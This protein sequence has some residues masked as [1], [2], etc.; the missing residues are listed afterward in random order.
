MYK[1]IN[2]ILFIF[3]L[4]FIFNTVKAE[5]SNIVDISKWSFK[6]LTNRSDENKNVVISK[7]FNV[8]D[9]SKYGFCIEPTQDFLPV[10]SLYYEETFDNKNIYNIV[11]AYN[12]IGLNNDDYYIAAQLLIWEELYQT[13]YTFNGN[14]YSKYKNEIIEYIKSN[15]DAIL[16]NSEQIYE[17][18][19]NELVTI[20]KDFSNY[21]IETDGIEIVEKDNIKLIYKII[22]KYPIN[23]TIKFIPIDDNK[24]ILYKSETSQDIYIHEGDFIE[25]EP[26]TI[27]V[28]TLLEPEYIDLKYSKKDTEGNVISNAE[29]TLFEINEN[30]E[31]EITFIQINTEIDLIKALLDN[32]TLYDNLHIEISERYSKYIKNNIINTNELGYFP[33]KIYDNNVLIKE[34]IVFVTN[35]VKQSNGM[36]SRIKTKAIFKGFSEDLSINNINNIE[37]DKLYYLCETEPRKGYTYVNKPCVLV[38]TSNY[39]QEIIE[40]INDN[41]LF[42][43][44]LMKNNTE[45]IYLNGA[46]FL[47]NIDGNSKEYITGSIRINRENNNKYLI[48]KNISNNYIDIVEFTDDFIILNNLKNG[49]YLYY[50]SN[51]NNIIDDLFIHELN[52]I[53]G[54]FIIDDI[55]YNSSIT[56]QEI[57]A[58][59]GYTID[60]NIYNINPD[61]KYNDITLTNYRVNEITIIPPEI[62]FIIPKT[63]IDD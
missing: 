15:N 26:F 37:K 16:F 27:D 2:K 34:G 24:D 44:K 14:N 21:G 39:N 54:G 59:K 40:F 47:V 63:C 35:D 4:L 58:P 55:P 22:E 10:G 25:L 60:N 62:D 17:S 9:R 19:V 32:D 50:Q 6:M 11:K 33:Y 23:K 31:D 36:H 46:H 45:N 8:D 48:Y 28:I 5:E 53:N 3:L 12:S 42:S 20:N 7:Y 38:D 18:K 56:V 1:K 41:R 29:F 43:L 57:I 52:V 30:Y 61:L 51:N 49:Q 13:T